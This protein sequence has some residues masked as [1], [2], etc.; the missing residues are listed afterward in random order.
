MSYVDLKKFKQGHL[1]FYL[2]RKNY[3]MYI[4][5]D[6]AMTAELRLYSMVDFLHYQLMSSLTAKVDR[7]L[8]DNQTYDP[9]I[10]FGK[11]KSIQNLMQFAI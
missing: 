8:S 4:F 9:T 7:I 11:G 1:Q 6:K 2:I 3:F 5:W 10:N